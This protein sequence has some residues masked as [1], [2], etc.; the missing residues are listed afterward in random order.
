MKNLLIAFPKEDILKN[1]FIE[2]DSIEAY[3]W[4]YLRYHFKENII[5]YLKSDAADRAELSLLDGDL[6]QAVFFARKLN[7]ARQAKLGAWLQD[8]EARLEKERSLKVL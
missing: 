1:K 7:N 4:G 6:S 5:G 2:S 8:A 3:F